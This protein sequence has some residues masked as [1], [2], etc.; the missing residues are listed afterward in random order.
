MVAEARAQGY[1]DTDIEPMT[2]SLVLLTPLAGL[3]ALALVVPLAGLALALRLERRGR[4]LLRLRPPPAAARLPLVIGLAAVPALLGLAAAQPAL[5]SATKDR[6]R[7]DAQAFFVLDVSR[8]MLAAGGPGGPTRLARAKS[9]ASR[10]RA[11][12][13]ELPAGIAT[14]TDRVLPDL[15]PIPG[16]SAFDNTL[17]KAVAIEQPPPESAGVEAT[18]LGSLGDLGTQNYFPPSIRSRLVIVLTDGESRAF[19]AS[20][21]ARAL[22][23]GPGIHTIFVHVWSAGEQIFGPGGRPEPGYHPDPASGQALASL[24]AAAGGAS[25]EERDLGAVSQAARAAVG[26]GPT[27]LRRTAEHT[28]TLAPYVALAALVPLALL[29]FGPRLAAAVS[30]GARATRAPAAR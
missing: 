4:E 3:A 11:L 17:E 26:P 14:M 5:R 15:M 20:S 29:L 10:L 6:V 19:D 2:A 28:R 7:T 21:V 25:F 24:A 12:L 9:D 30:R 23:R 27:T 13:P 16:G 22:A 18:T 1:P 8:S